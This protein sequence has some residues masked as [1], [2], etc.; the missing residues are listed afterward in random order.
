M[1]IQTAS[2]PA[3][4]GAS[5]DTGSGAVSRDQWARW[6]VASVDTERVMEPRPGPELSYQIEFDETIKYPE[7][8]SH[9]RP[10]WQEMLENSSTS[11]H[12][13]PSTARHPDYA[14][15]RRSLMKI[16]TSQIQIDSGAFKGELWMFFSHS[17]ALKN[18]EPLVSQQCIVDCVRTF[19]TKVVKCWMFKV[20]FKAANR[21]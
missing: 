12:S 16:S 13:F 1:V 11:L 7:M 20:T 4:K 14:M 3:L 8:P 5:K 19:F 17:L 9:R 2:H 10:W 18:T 6:T 15:A 21:S